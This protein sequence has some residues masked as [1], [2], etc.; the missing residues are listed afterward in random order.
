MLWFEAEMLWSDSKGL[1]WFVVPVLV[2]HSSWRRFWV[3]TQPCQTGTSCVECALSPQG[4]QCWN[5]K[6]ISRSNRIKQ[7]T[8]LSFDKKKLKSHLPSQTFVGSCFW[9]VRICCVCVFYIIVHWMSLQT[10][11]FLHTRI[12]KRLPVKNSTALVPLNKKRA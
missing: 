1:V 12:F 9:N 4:F 7:K 8:A 11:G 3:E 5:T 10:D 2:Q 6:R